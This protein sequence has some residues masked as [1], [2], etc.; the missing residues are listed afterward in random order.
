MRL[1]EAPDTSD[2]HRRRTALGP[3][4]RAQARRS[5]GVG[6]EVSVLGDQRAAAPPPA[7][8]SLHAWAFEEGG[9]TASRWTPLPR[10]A[11][12][13]DRAAQAISGR[14][15][16]GAAASRRVIEHEDG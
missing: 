14:A 1:N 8:I 11:D 6:L 7:Q 2:F 15:G 16:G 13:S 3:S 12:K 5:L 10:P 9:S 4:L